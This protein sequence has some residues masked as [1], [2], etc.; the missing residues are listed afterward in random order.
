MLC[1]APSLIG[2]NVLLEQSHPRKV[3]LQHAVPGA[4]N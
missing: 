1:T 2:E 4:P 3:M